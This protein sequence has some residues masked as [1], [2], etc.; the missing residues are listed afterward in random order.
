MTR[1]SK[2]LAIFQQMLA[3]ITLLTVIND[4]EAHV[5]RVVELARIILHYFTIR[6]YHNLTKTS[7][8]YD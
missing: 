1:A 4:L 3:F 7:L 8:I 2:Y 6:F 5:K